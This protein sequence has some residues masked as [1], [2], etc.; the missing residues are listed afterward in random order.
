MATAASLSVNARVTGVSTV[1]P[2]NDVARL[3][4]YL[5]CVTVSVGIDILD[6]DLVDYR[7]YRRLSPTRVALVMRYAL[8]L[9]P[10]ELIGQLIF[11]DDEGEV[12]GNSSNEFCDINVACNIISIQR[13]ALI[14]GRVQNVTKVMFF[15]SSWLANNYTRPLMRLSRPVITARPVVRRQPSNDCVVS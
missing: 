12:C 4:Y 1:I 5:R 14:G 15:K 10:R 7:N 13:E 8:A 6:D 3:M 9:D 11:L 2:D